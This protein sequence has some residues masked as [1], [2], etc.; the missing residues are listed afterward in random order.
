[1]IGAIDQ[2]AYQLLNGLSG[3][4]WFLDALAGLALDSPL[5][6]AG[7][8]GAAFVFAWYHGR[9]DADLARA[10]RVL[11]VTFGAALIVVAI[12][13]TMSH[14]IV[15]PRPYVEAQKVEYL[16]DGKLIE[17][18]RWQHRVPLEGTGR[19]KAQ[20]LARGT[21]GDGDMGAFPS[22]HAAF[23]LTIALGIFLACRRAGAVAI[24]WTLIVTLGSRIVT[25]AHSPWQVVA[26][27]LIGLAV[28]LPLV[29][30]SNRFL[31][32]PFDRIAGWTFRWPGL[33]AALVFLAA[34]EIT[35]TLEGIHQVAGFALDAVKAL[36]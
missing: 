15:E 8:I 18:P 16:K 23:Y 1:M 34:F 21:I 6:K 30:L 25:G 31:R 24:G 3:R 13:K 12:S 5:F 9:A 28:L 35:E 11:M 36:A 26:G 22:D 14:Q 32:R 10:R 17:A 4:S 29:W 33:S 20:A 2:H 19:N 7:V 27:G